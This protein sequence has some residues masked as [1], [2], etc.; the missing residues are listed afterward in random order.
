MGS[1]LMCLSF[2]DEKEHTHARTPTTTTRT[3]EHPVSAFYVWVSRPY[4]R[5]LLWGLGIV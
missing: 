1:Y 4:S 3:I 5:S 2:P